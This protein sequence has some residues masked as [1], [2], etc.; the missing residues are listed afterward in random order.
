MTKSVYWKAGSTIVHTP[1]GRLFKRYC[2]NI[3]TTCQ[4]SRQKESRFSQS[5]SRRIRRGL[6]PDAPP[7]R[8]N[9]GRHACGGCS[10]PVF[11]DDGGSP[12]C[13]T[14]QRLSMEKVIAVG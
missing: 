5:R 11:E 7:N 4:Q 9:I 1:A 8:K 6:M 2:P 13:Y 10:A 3:T 14:P 12:P